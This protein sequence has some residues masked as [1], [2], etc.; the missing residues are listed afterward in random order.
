M[1]IRGLNPEESKIF[2]SVR[3]A[4]YIPC[5]FIETYYFKKEF[6]AQLFKGDSIGSGIYFGKLC[7]NKPLSHSSWEREEIRKLPASIRCFDAECARSI[8]VG[9]QFGC[10]NEI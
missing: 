9:W 5:S 2:K 4:T 7:V 1:R 8:V 3:F 10:V 6:N